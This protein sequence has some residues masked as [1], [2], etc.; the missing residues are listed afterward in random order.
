MKEII[1]LTTYPPRECGIATFSEDLIRAIETKFGESFSVKVCALESSSE[2]HVY[3]ARV[4]YVFNTSRVSDFECIAQKINEDEDVKIVLIQHEFGLFAEHPSALL[5]F[6]SLIQKPVIVVFHTVL[7][8]PSAEQKEYLSRLIGYCSSV[9]VMTKTSAGILENEYDVESEKI[10]IIPHG[11]HLVSHKDKKKLKEKYQVTGHRILSTFGLLS[12]GKS[13]ET[14]LEALP[15]I[16]KENPSVLFLIIGKTHPAVLKKDGEVYRE[17]LKEKIRELKLTDHV[18]FVNFYLD[19]PILLEYLQLTDVYLFTSE[20]P[21]QA[22]SGTFV[23]ALSCGCPIIAT[24]IPHALELLKDNSGLIFDFKNSKQ[25]SKK[26]NELLGNEK[27]RSRMR[28]AGLEKTA[29][30]AWENTA[31]AYVSLFKRLLKDDEAISYSLP[32]INIEHIKRMS[33]SFAMLQFSKGNRPD[34]HYGY[35]LDDNA[36]ALIALCRLYIET[37]DQSC[38]KYIKKYL[39]FIRF[40][41]QANGCFLN[42]V[43]KDH[44][45]THQNEEVGLEDSNAR[46][47][48]ALGYF[49]AQTGKFPDVWTEDALESF[50]QTFDIVREMKSPRSMAFAIKGLFYFQQTY[51]SSET[52]ELITLLADK[53]VNCYQ[54]NR[55]D[56]WKWFEAYL[57]YDNS[58]LPESLLYAYQISNNDTYKEIAEESFHFLLDNTF[59]EEQIKVVS[60]QGWRQKAASGKIYGEQPIDIAGTVIALSTF[61]SILGKNEYY[62]KQKIAFSWFLGNNHLE[63]IIY[64]PS[65]GGCYDGLEEYNV[66]LNQGAESTISYL[67]ARLCMGS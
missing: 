9:V 2:Q 65:T 66:N 56:G 43:D 33:H 38:E 32:P 3:D 25:L 62:Q 7:P 17:M 44:Q 23:Y 28:I 35:T 4:K 26:V 31:I 18:R 34:I 15:D 39:D 57:T 24:P 60:N 40:C 45:F 64:N 46:A 27:L 29:A 42:Y 55:E 14:T 10:N 21:N 63:Q 41:Q 11:T 30:T 20:D 16:V 36:R 13:I 22:V 51:P 58:V 50:E 48:Y 53:L 6:G 5:V 47:I 67:M 1:C 61:Y 19:L 54:A 59:K 8:C 12:P 37:K 49:I 52:F